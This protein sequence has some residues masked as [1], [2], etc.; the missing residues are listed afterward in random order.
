MSTLNYQRVL[1]AVLDLSFTALNPDLD[2]DP[3]DT[4]VSAVLLFSSDDV[5]EIGSSRRFTPADARITLPGKQGAIAESIESGE[6]LLIED[7]KQDEELGRIITL[8]TCNQVY[9]FPLL[10]G[11]NVYGV[12]I[13][14]H[15]APGYFTLDRQEILD[16]LGRQVVIAIQNARLYQDLV[17]ERDKMIEVQEEA[18]KKLARDLH[19]GPTQSIAA[20]TMRLGMARM[21][22]EKDPQSA[23]EEIM[24]IEDLAQRTSKEIRHML[25]TLRPL[26]LE[27]QG[28][29]AALDSMAEKMKE[30][31]DQ[32]IQLD[33]NAQLL[34]RID[35]SKQNV[36][37]FIVEEAITNARKH[38][39]ANQIW[40]RLRPADRDLAFLEIKDD[41]IG[42]DVQ[43]VNRAYDDRGSLGMV[44]LRD[45]A[46]LINGLLQIESEPGSGTRVQVA[47]PL[48][49]DAADRLHHAAGRRE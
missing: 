10:S 20:L 4:L 46:E 24:R 43:E 17:E 21:L 28:L 47:I 14:G 13:F 33:I 7:V 11:F 27:S 49:E 35:M 6:P 1:D 18:R 39:R 44:N 25:F 9:C 12:L 23:G 32:E 36:I 45:R 29:I 37:F 16:I 41:G 42:F 8:R 38:A 34:E 26:A 3:K 22:L 31:Y 2:S 15:P 40:V 5:L 19:D 48:S 30:T